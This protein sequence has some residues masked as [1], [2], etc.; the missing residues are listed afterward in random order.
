VKPSLATTLSRPVAV[1]TVLLAIGAALAA[2]QLVAGLLAPESSP[3]LQVGDAVIRLAPQGVVEFA[4]ATFGT[5]DKPVLLAGIAVVLLLVAVGAGLAS[6]RFATAGRITVG[7]LGVVGIAA[8]AT[9]P[10]FAPTDLLAPVVAAGVGWWVF[11]L[12]HR[13]AMEYTETPQGVTR[14]RFL[15]ATAAVGGGVVLGGGAGVLLGRPT[16]DSRTAVTA[17]LAAATIAREP[18]TGGDFETTPYLTPNP[19]FYRIDTALRVP[20]LRAEDW[21][22][23]VHGMVG[24][25]LTL[26]FEDLLA[27]P[28][29]ERT[30][31]LTCVSNEVGGDLISTA[32]FVGVELA[33]VLR[34]A[35]PLAGADQV[36]S[37]STDG[38]TAGTPVDV[39]F[40]P[41]RGALLAVGMNGEALPTEHGF[42]VRMVVPGLY[43]YVSATKWV[44]D[45]ELTTFAAHEA[46]WEQRGWGE[47]GPIKT[48]ARIDLP[49]RFTTVPAGP[50][51]VAGIAW[52]QPRGIARVEY[53]VD[54]G[55]WSEAELADTVGGNT[56]RMWRGTA[57]V[58][59]GSHTMR[60]RATDGTGA[61][62][63][64]QAADVLPDGATG[65]PAV[66]FTAR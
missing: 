17:R 59:P 19:D 50:V 23:R 39:L 30:V 52:S 24:R 49:R 66:I 31:T 28:L 47:R 43:G 64:E 33:E 7:V 18:G 38:W 25:E 27:R 53:S 3:F 46:Y 60:V 6:R 32:R 26:S 13:L 12:L 37:T 9:D 8:T 22:L 2:G 14:R 34:E 63:T 55:P 42:P 10:T 29:V 11:G 16:V 45:L 5:A 61:L 40:E 58:G 15:Q 4:K 48:E 41:G 44:T 62:Q 56:W 65:W 21:S 35:G 36:L 54:G 57:D 20:Q 51:T 1:G